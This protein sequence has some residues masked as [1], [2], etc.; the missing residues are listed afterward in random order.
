MATW[1]LFFDSSYA[2][3]IGSTGAIMAVG[4]SLFAVPMLMWG[5]AIRKRRGSLR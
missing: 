3:M 2:P 5:A 4:S 1:Q